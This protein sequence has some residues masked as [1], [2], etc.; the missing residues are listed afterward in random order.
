MTAQHLLTIEDNLEHV[1]F[2]QRGR[3]L[4]SIGLRQTTPE[5]QQ[6]NNLPSFVW[7][8][9]IHD[10]K[11]GRVAGKPLVQGSVTTQATLSPDGRYVAACGF[12]PSSFAATVSL[13][14]QER[15][16]EVRLW[17]LETGKLIASPL[18]HDAPV[19]HVTF[20]ADS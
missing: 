6:R 12:R 7:I 18:R 11:E 1:A 2:Q 3:Y 10:L 4:V 13:A 20:G 5:A 14:E 19:T 8:V 16:Q 9:R 17:E 15:K